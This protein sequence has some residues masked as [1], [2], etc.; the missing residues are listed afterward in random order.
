MWYWDILPLAIEMVGLPSFI[1]F[2]L[3]HDIFP[4]RIVHPD[5]HH[6]FALLLV[7]WLLTL[8]PNIFDA[9]KKQGARN[10]P[11]SKVKND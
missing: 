11:M 9:F 10:Q 4:S 2:K 3:F 6:I 1:T 5:T 8:G 7:S